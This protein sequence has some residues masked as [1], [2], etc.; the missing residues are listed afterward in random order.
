MTHPVKTISGPESAA[1]ADWAVLFNGKDI[2]AIDRRQHKST[3]GE[4]SMQKRTFGRRGQ[5]NE[6]RFD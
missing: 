6:R 1:Y 4:L 5:G 2:G 3:Q